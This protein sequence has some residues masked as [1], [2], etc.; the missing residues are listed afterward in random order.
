MEC[1]GRIISEL[2]ARL[3]GPRLQPAPIPVRVQR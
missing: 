2:L 3:G 1:I